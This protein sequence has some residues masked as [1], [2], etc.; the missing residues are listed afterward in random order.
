M[1]I[2][3]DTILDQ[4]SVTSDKTS[5]VI[6]LN[7]VQD[8]A[9]QIIWTSTSAAGTFVVQ[10]S[11]NNS[12]WVDLSSHTKTI[13]NNNGNEMIVISDANYAYLRVFLDYTSGTV[14]TAKVII[15]GKGL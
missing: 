9:I 14:T 7:F 2:F 5:E 3:N 13:N 15:N 8:I 10:C 11:N 4:S 1:R 6:T 12:N